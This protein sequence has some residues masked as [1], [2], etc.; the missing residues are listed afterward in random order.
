MNLRQY[1]DWCRR[2]TERFCFVEYDYGDVPA[3]K[4]GHFMIRM[5]SSYVRLI[6]DAKTQHLP[7]EDTSTMEEYLKTERAIKWVQFRDEHKKKM[8]KKLKTVRVTQYEKEAIKI[9]MEMDADKAKQQLED[10]MQGK[11]KI[12]PLGRQAMTMGEKADLVFALYPK[13]NYQEGS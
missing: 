11:T 9:Q 13:D 5:V 12:S 4:L 2:Y 6:A 7:R 8:L 1:F 10:V 3:D